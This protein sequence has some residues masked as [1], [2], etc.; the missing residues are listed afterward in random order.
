MTR[1][2]EIYRSIR[3]D[4]SSGKITPGERL[5]SVRELAKRFGS[6]PGTVAQTLNRLRFEQIIVSRQGAGCFASG[7]SAPPKYLVVFGRGGQHLFEDYIQG[8]YALLG[9]E[10]GY[11]VTLEDV[12]AANFSVDAAMSKLGQMAKAGML[13]GIFMEGTQ[14]VIYTIDQMNEFKKLSNQLYV[15]GCATKQFLRANIPGV[16]VDWREAGYLQT[17]YLLDSGCR[18]IVL[19]PILEELIPGMEDALREFKG[20]VRVHFTGKLRLA[21]TI[22]RSPERFDG[23]AM[24]SDHCIAKIMPSLKQRG[25]GNPAIVGLFHTPWSREF[26]FASVDIRPLE[27]VRLIADMFRG[28][29]PP[30]LHECKPVLAPPSNETLLCNPLSEVF[31]KN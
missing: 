6:S 19:E 26:N 28:R 14:D 4:I 10:P 16:S 17:R 9:H 1:H 3:N 24:F 11:S 15:Y 31:L 13:G 30:K 12:G 29:I 27:M 20:K 8:F 2:E 25:Y 5:P 7:R 21:D 22:L 23:I 18:N